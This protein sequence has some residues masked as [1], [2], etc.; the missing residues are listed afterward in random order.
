[1]RKSTKA[2]LI[3]AAS[4]VLIGCILFA[5]VT[6]AIG[7][8]FSKLSTVRWETNTYEI[9][10]PF[11]DISVT[12]DTADIVFALSDDGKCRVVC[13]EEEN[14]KHSAA[15][16]GD[17]LVIQRTDTGAWYDY[18]GLRFG[19]PG[20]TVY[21]PNTD[22]GSVKIKADTGNIRFEDFSVRSLD[23]SV[24]TGAVTV[25]DVTC[26][27]DITVNVSTG[28]VCLTGISCA[29][30]ISSGTTG[31]IFLDDVVAAEK[32]SI[33]RSTGSVRFEGSDAAEIFV[34]TS[35]GSV[36]GDL[37]TD[38]VF[39]ADTD[40]GSVDVPRS[41]TGGRCEIETNTGNI[42]ITTG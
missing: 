22:V 12:T 42:A 26:R 28:E 19:T 38:K 18:L 13:R 37:L 10:E 30:V 5:A 24:T 11:S 9:T 27:G 35:T 40:T 25:T 33:E 20:I 32:F 36:T 14:A 29:S 41:E 16:E 31:S 2:W 6:A 17:A 21:L 34:K 39:A 7:G 3:V 15:V 1:M 8:N 23:L 4:L